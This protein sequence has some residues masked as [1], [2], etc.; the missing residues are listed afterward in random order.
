[1]WY[2]KTLDITIFFGP[3]ELMCYF[4]LFIANWY[5][6]ISDL[7]NKISQSQ[8]SCYTLHKIPDF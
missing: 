7:T 3:N 5:N 8:G 2:K 4:L 1:M 6:K